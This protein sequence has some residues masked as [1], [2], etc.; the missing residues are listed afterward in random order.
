MMELEERRDIIEGN[1][2]IEGMREVRARDEL[3]EG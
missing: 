3:K 1:N 2:I